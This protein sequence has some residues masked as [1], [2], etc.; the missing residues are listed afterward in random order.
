MLGFPVAAAS[1]AQAHDPAEGDQAAD[2]QEQAVRL[3]DHREGLERS[4]GG[5]LRRRQPASTLTPKSPPTSRLRPSAS[6][7]TGTA[8]LAPSA[9]SR[10]QLPSEAWSLASADCSV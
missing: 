8:G 7:M 10:D 4:R 1:P 5:G 9:L 3:R 6:G 2:H